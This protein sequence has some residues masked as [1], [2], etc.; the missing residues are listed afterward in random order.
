MKE[1]VIGY[2]VSI[3]EKNR[4]VV[5]SSIRRDLNIKNKKTK[6][7]LQFCGKQLNVSLERPKKGY[8]IPISIDSQGRLLIPD[9]EKFFKKSVLVSEFNGGFSIFPKR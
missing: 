1:K 4:I 5:P 2:D 3:D 7:F 9:A 8:F 6:I